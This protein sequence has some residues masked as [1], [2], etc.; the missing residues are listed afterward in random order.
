MVAERLAPPSLHPWP[1]RRPEHFEIS[2]VSFKVK[3][4]GNEMTHVAS[5][6]TNFFEVFHISLGMQNGNFEGFFPDLMGNFDSEVYIS[7]V[8]SQPIRAI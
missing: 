5:N 8:Y 4:A 3:G 1:L 7:Q 2:R 6:D